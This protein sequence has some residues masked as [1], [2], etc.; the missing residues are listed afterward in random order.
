M[1]IAVA[2]GL[3]WLV[4]CLGA[5]AT[6]GHPPDSGTNQLQSRVPGASCYRVRIGT[7]SETGQP[8]GLVPPTEFRLD[9]TRS[10]AQFATDGA[11]EAHP[12]IVTDGQDRRYPGFWYER[13]A[14]SLEIAW[15]TGFQRGGYRLRVR[16]DAAE[17]IA[18]TWTDERTGNPDPTAPVTGSRVACES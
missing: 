4:T 1:R 13:G 6:P 10:R 8:R 7:W 18:T 5:C 16:G 12:D 2:A 3:S 11:R 9:T 15:N 14:D 17:G